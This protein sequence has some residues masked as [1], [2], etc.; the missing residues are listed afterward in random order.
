MY[1]PFNPSCLPSRDARTSGV[2][3]SPKLTTFSSRSMGKTSRYRHKSGCRPFN[4]SFVKEAAA[5]SKS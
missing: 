2:N 1:S 4:D 5:L 3:P